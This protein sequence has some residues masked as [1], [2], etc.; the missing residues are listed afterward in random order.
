VSKPERRILD[1]WRSEIRSWICRELNSVRIA[2][3]AL[4]IELTEENWFIGNFE[5]FWK[6]V[7][8]VYGQAKNYADFNAYLMSRIVNNIW[9]YNTVFSRFSECQQIFEG[10]FCYLLSNFEEYSR[11]VEESSSLLCGMKNGVR[12]QE[13]ETIP[14]WYHCDC[15]SKARLK[16]EQKTGSLIGRG[17]CVRCEKEYVLDFGSSNEP[18]MADYIKRVSARSLSMPLVF[19]NGLKV[20]CYIGG[21]GGTTYLQQAQRVSEHLGMTFAP[22]AVWR[23]RDVYLGVGQMEAF[24]TFKKLSGSFDFSKYSQAEN[25]FREKVLAVQNKIDELEAQKKQL[26]G[27]SNP[28]KETQVQNLKALSAKQNELRRAAA[29]PELKS[30][31]G[32]LENVSAVMNLYPCIVDY[33]VNIG[34]KETSEQWIDFLQNNGNL[35]SNVRLT[36]PFDDIGVISKNLR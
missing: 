22:V 3:K 36:T 2:C 15:G 29:F 20:S 32:L 12:E 7:E 9:E 27:C 28:Q 5:A 31:L 17:R 8:E 10:E 6:L 35:S 1:A 30:N 14:F 23:P 24:I 16:A 25:S 18:R 26:I 11:C 4:G 33:A 13:S 19:F 21:V 34:L